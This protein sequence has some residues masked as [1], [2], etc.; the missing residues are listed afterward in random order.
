MPYGLE[1]NARGQIGKE[2][3]ESVYCIE[4]LFWLSRLAPKIDFVCNRGRRR[5]WQIARVCTKNER[6]REIVS[7]APHFPQKTSTDDLM[8]DDSLWSFL[9][10]RS[11]RS[12]S[13]KNKFAQ[14]TAKRQRQQQQPAPLT[15]GISLVGNHSRKDGAKPVKQ[16]RTKHQQQHSDYFIM[17][18]DLFDQF[19]YQS[20]ALNGIWSS[21]FQ[22]WSC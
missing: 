1:C 13:D 2:N 16:K 12:W 4:D 21:I 14:F 6:G 8:Q 18:I 5:R 19:R 3:I 10:C 7:T 22:K 15:Q 20:V 11:L 17:L 9:W